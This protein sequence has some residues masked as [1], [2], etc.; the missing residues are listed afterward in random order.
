MQGGPA[1]CRPDWP[2]RELEGTTERLAPTESTAS[3]E[4]ASTK[5]DRPDKLGHLAGGEGSE[6]AHWLDSLQRWADGVSC[7][8]GQRCNM[9]PAGARIGAR[10]EKVRVRFGPN[11]V[12][13]FWAPPEP[14]TGL[15]VRFRPYADPRTGLRSGSEK[16]RSDPRFRTGLR[17]HYKDRPGGL[18]TLL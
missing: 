18:M 9:Q 13:H 5:P 6:D 4:V 10:R 3:I 15:W 8:A 1:A 17:N 11:P 2:L 14:R 7:M 12:H 16:F